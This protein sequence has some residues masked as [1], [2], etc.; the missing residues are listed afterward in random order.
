MK[1]YN[2]KNVVQGID[3]AW[4]M[5]DMKDC[6]VKSVECDKKQRKKDTVKR[7]KLKTVQRWRSKLEKV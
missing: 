5:C 7:D 2:I 4:N 3:A 1:E 6:S